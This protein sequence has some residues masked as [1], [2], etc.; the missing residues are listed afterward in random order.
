[1]WSSTAIPRRRRVAA[2]ASSHGSCELCCLGRLSSGADSE[3]QPW[4]GATRH[5]VGWQWVDEEDGL[6]VPLVPRSQ[7][8]I[9]VDSEPNAGGVGRLDVHANTLPAQHSTD[10]NHQPLQ[11]AHSLPMHVN[12]VPKT[13]HVMRYISA[14]HPQQHRCICG[15]DDAPIDVARMWTAV[16]QQLLQGPTW[17]SRRGRR[18][19]EGGGRWAAGAGGCGASSEDEA[20]LVR[21]AGQTGQQLTPSAIRDASRRDV[22][23]AT[24]RRLSSRWG[25]VTVLHC[26][27]HHISQ[28][29]NRSSGRSLT[30]PFASSPSTHT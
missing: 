15:S 14:H 24:S 6:L 16:G 27:L 3:R 7:T 26:S 12:P 11:A 9:A 29:L 8:L 18:D 10:F 17:R 28:P 13:P 22:A 25:D 23:A 20:A 19:R 30:A 4:D 21:D 2:V 5:R 1:M